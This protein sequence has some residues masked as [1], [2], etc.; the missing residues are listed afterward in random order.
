MTFWHGTAPIVVGSGNQHKV[1]E[2][3]A[4][5][6]QLAADQIADRVGSVAD[7]G[8]MPP[9]VEDQ[10][11]F[12]GNARKKALAVARSTGHLALADDSGL[13]V[14]VL[15]GAPGIFSARWAGAASNDQ[16]NRDLLLE[17]LA[18]VPDEHRQAAFHCV[19]VLAAPAGD[20]LVAEGALAG[21]LARVSA[22]SAGFGYDPIFV[23]D[24]Y[25]CTAAELTSV[26]KNAISH[27]KAALEN[28]VQLMASS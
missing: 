7:Y 6:R 10:V 28:L 1:T 2:I 16:T 21:K 11:T 25:S 19:L 8:G 27:R 23:P 15:G 17:Q 9:V 13:A 3:Q 4:I 22:G 26:Q 18:D 5:L 12:A 24:G 14:T 20:V